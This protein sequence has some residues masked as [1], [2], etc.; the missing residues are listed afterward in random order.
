MFLGL[1]FRIVAELIKMIYLF[2]LLF[3]MEINE[4]CEYFSR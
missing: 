2:F 3:P 4:A 1:V